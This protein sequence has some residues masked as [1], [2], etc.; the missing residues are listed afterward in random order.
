[1]EAKKK[2]KV[3][4]GSYEK[5]PLLTRGGMFQV[6]NNPSG[7]QHCLQFYYHMHGSGI[8]TLNVYGIPQNSLSQLG[9]PLWTRS[10]DQGNH[11]RKAAV[12]ISVT[13][14][15]QVTTIWLF[16]MCSGVVLCVVVFGGVGWG[17]RGVVGLFKKND[18]GGWGNCWLYVHVWH[19][20]E[21]LLFLFVL[22]GGTNKE[23]RGD[24]KIRCFHIKLPVAGVFQVAVWGLR[25]VWYSGL[26]LL[27]SG[28][29]LMEL[30]T[31]C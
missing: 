1:M 17:E 15:F 22:S 21:L 12:T 27:C 2:K 10:H 29:C 31:L 23:W 4:W 25:A 6:Y 30:C 7:S 8:G 16:C 20:V 24:G 9:A 28:Q 13:S 5:K 18:L 11:W 3:G 26:L 14:N 19:L